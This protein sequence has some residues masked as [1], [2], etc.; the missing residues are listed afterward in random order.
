MADKTLEFWFDFSCPY[1]Y[2]ASTQVE[3]LAER[4]GAKLIAKP[5]LLGGI[6][7]AVGTD[8]KL[9]A[10]LGAAK[11]A[12][13]GRDLDRHAKLWDV[14][15]RFPGD[16][17]MRTVTALRAM[18]VVGEPYMP[19]AHAFYRAYWDTNEDLGDPDVV[20]RILSE[21]GHDA[22]AVL[23]R[24]SDDDVKADL[25][26]R[27]DEAIELGFFGVP[28]FRV[29]GEIYWG[30]DRMHFVEAALGGSPATVAQV[31]HRPA[32]DVLPVDFYFD[33]SSP[34]S[35]LAAM[36][37]P[38]Y[39]GPHA[40]WK[41]MLLGGVFKSVGTA[42]V[43]L[44]EASPA[45]QRYLQQDCNRQ[46]EEAN[47]EF[48]WPSRF[49]MNTV[50]PLRMTILAQTQDPERAQ[51]F[52]RATYVGFWGEDLDISNPEV[53]AKVADDAGFDGAALVAGT[54][55]QDIKD[56]LRRYTEEAVADGVFG[57]PSFVVR[58]SADNR[59]LYWGNDRLP[60]AVRAAQGDDRVV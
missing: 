8:Q 22:A 12:H 44:F 14:P 29:D 11:A 17:P 38:D 34:F 53:M 25:R 58:R 16:H 10:T 36:R 2:L 51:A 52:I 20:G 39:L 27:T 1:A 56:T 42:N 54:Q 18:L 40:R 55:N 6:F 43:P 47:A 33:Y 37:V 7:K 41:P 24:T 45:K 35:Y 19:L 4:A 3:A 46:A 57:A 49:P 28:G 30:Q 26:R 31:A 9:F 60:L 48:R 23:A 50:L 13:N 15:L 59:S 5:V 32:E 21:A